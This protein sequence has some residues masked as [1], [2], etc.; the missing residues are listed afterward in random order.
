[1]HI[2]VPSEIKNNE[3]RVAMTPAGVVEL[4]KQ[5]HV[6]TVEQRAGRT[7]RRHPETGHRRAAVPTR[8]RWRRAYAGAFTV[9]F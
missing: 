6:V 5:G 8:R 1:M 3:Y 2:G 7:A 9:W 4:L